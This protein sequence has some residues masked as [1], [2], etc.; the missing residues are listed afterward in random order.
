MYDGTFHE[1]VGSILAVAQLFGIMPVYGIK[2]KNPSQLR[3]KIF[4]FRFLFSIIYIVGC[5][6]SLSLT[7]HWIATSKLE[8]GKL[9]NFT[10]EFTNLMAIICFLELGRKWPDLIVNW[11]RVEK[12][13]PPLKYQFDKQKMAYQIKM[14]SLVILF[15]SMSEHLLSIT[16]GAHGANNCPTIKDPIKAFYFRNYP[17]VWLIFPYSGWLGSLTKFFNI[18]L[19]FAWSYT[20]LFVIIISIGLTSKFEQLNDELRKIKGRRGISPELWSEYR[21]YYREIVGLIAVV[22]KAVSK[23]ILISI[24]NNLFFIC[25]QLLRSLDKK[26]TFAHTFYFWISLSYLIGRTLAVSLYS[27]G[28][29]DASKKPLEVFRSVCREDWCIEVK[30]FNEEVAHDTIALS[31]MKFFYLTRKLVLSVA[32]TIVTYELVLIQF[33]QDDNIS[34]WDPCLTNNKTAML[35]SYG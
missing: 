34:D 12:F 16:V 5:M 23:I 20:D 11:Y 9:I 17:Q 35:M 8:F 10:F 1:A 19:T 7:V 22:D 33:H 28:I 25:V 18:I 24:S 21:V 30:R 31:G 3:F 26:P 2:E 15:S 13:L 27:A 4:S 14:A 32:G 6:L 29:N